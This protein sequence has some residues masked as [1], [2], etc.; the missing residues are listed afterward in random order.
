MNTQIIKDLILRKGAALISCSRADLIE[1]EGVLTNEDIF[2]YLS[3]C[4]TTES[5]RASDIHVGG[6][7]REMR[8]ANFELSPGALLFP[9]GFLSIASD[10]G[11]NEICVDGRTGR[12]YFAC[13]GSFDDQMVYCTNQV[14][15]ELIDL[16]GLNYDNIIMG[17]HFLSEDLESFLVRLLRD[18]LTGVLD[19]FD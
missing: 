15:G 18:E 19:H 6:N 14:T 5:Y 3:E 13:Q 2:Q 7:I 11:G 8:R 17:L 9:Y 12:V 4:Q 16:K 1:F 10:I